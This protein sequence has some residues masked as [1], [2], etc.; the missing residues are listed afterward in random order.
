MWAPDI[1]VRA[2]SCF[3][4]RSILKVLE[5]NLP[6]V[7]RGG[8]RA[9]A[10][11]CERAVRGMLWGGGHMKIGHQMYSWEM[12]GPA[13]RGTPDDIMDMVAA[14]GYA[15]IEFSSAMIGGYAERPAEF[16]RALQRRGLA[17]AAFAGPRCL[18]PPAHRAH[19]PRSS[20]GCRCPEPLAAAG[21]RRVRFSRY[22]PAAPRQRIPG[23]AGERGG[24]GRGPAGPGRRDCGKS[25]LPSLTRGVEDPRRLRV[26]SVR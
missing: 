13:W 3:N 12:Q 21:S 23:L 9:A 7:P 6:R 15:G 26:Y 16:Q 20:Q 19:R 8:R 1:R 18:L 11:L 17:A 24:V 25:G 4:A 2:V 5:R 10:R 14:A 22:R